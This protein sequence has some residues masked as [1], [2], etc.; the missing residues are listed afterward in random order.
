MALTW[1]MVATAVGAPASGSAPPSSTTVAQSAVPAKPPALVDIAPASAPAGE[2]YPVTLT[3]RGSGFMPTGNVVDIGP[4]TIPDVP[5]AEPGR[6]TVRVPKSLPSK[7]EAPPLVLIAGEYP[8]TVTT[9]GGTS[10]A[11]TFRLTR[12][13]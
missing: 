13:P 11:L 6:I 8:V 4:V 1:I 2:A 10:N 7:A 5:S 3:I 9:P 12:G